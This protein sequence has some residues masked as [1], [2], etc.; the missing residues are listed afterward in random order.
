MADDRITIFY[1]SIIDNN[2]PTH[3]KY[4]VLIR[5]V[6][7]EGNILTPHFFLEIAKKAKLY[8]QLTKI[9]LNKAFEAFKDNDYDFSINITIDDILDKDINKYIIETLE[10]YNIS[11]R[12]IFEI[13]ESES[14][15]NFDIVEK[16]IT[17]VK[18]YGCRI[19]IDDFGTGY[20]NFEHLMRLQ[21]DYIKID[22]SIIKEITTNKRSELITSIIIAFAKEMNI[23]TIG[24]YVETKEIN[25]K[26]IELGVNKSQGYYFDKPQATL[27]K[28]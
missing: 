28:K 4:E 27:E 8:K 3:K 21:A 6:D 1:Q 23:E 18:E 24:E 2:D 15:D 9:V 7:K 20:S 19:S 5:L 26:L 14:I 25:D 17:M 11:N 22:G 10:K 13:V 12:V 16:F